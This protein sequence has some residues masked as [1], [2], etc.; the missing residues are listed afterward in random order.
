M[1]APDPLSNPVV[2]TPLATEW[3]DSLGFV[4]RRIGV[5]DTWVHAIDYGG[6]GQV[7]VFLAGLG[8]TAHVFDGF[9]PRFTNRFHVLGITRRGYGE[10]GRPS[11]GFGTGRLVED[12]RTVL[13]SLDIDRVVLV[14]HS[15][16]GD[17]LTGFAVRH[18]ERTIALVYLE[19][20]Y[21]RHGMSGRMLQLLM[22]DQL[23][24]SAPKPGNRD[25]VSVM[26][27]QAYLQSIYGVLWPLS[28]VRATKR[29]DINGRLLGDSTSG[30]T[31]V[32]VM[33]GEERMQYERIRSP[34]L[35]LYAVNRS[36]YR[37]YP[38]IRHMTVGRGVKYQQAAR[39]S[40][41]QN[42]FERE[43][44][45]RLR[46]ALPAARIVELEDASHYLFISDA[47]RVE[48]EMRE[49]LAPY[50]DIGRQR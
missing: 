18:P 22:L 26:A 43:E 17:E 2:V 31:G 49:F 20:A 21:D 41:A 37:D 40:R 12:I 34:V 35:A 23:P 14:G 6:H 9:A 44:R 24:P 42:Q 30:T 28:E 1:R 7:L 39:A 3:V 27:T 11:G 47:D 32:K 45:E 36:T 19:A 16:A 33:R 15:V 25:R 5:G 38:W 13:D 10:S 29:F 4:N 46:E 48:A 8:N 50:Q